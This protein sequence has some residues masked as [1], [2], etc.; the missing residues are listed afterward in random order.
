[1]GFENFF[2]LLSLSSMFTVL[3]PNPS[4]INRF[5]YFP[6][7]RCWDVSVDCFWSMGSCDIL[8]VLF[9]LGVWCIAYISV[10]IF[11]SFRILHSLCSIW[12]FLGRFCSVTMGYAQLVIGPAGSG[13][14]IYMVFAYQFCSVITVRFCLMRFFLGGGGVS[15][16]SVNLLL[17][18]V[19]TLWNRR[20]NNECC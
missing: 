12:V 18:F 13:K 16:G 7:F 9:G 17:I 2:R 14:V 1:M 19:W 3:N 4:Y 5:W 20:Q 11:A 8:S 10:A 6:C 15:F